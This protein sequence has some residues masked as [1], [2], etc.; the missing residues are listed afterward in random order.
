MIIYYSSLSKGRSLC[1]YSST[2]KSDIRRQICIL[3]WM[4]CVRLNKGFLWCGCSTI[5]NQNRALLLWRPPTICFRGF[6]LSFNP[7][8]SKWEHLA[9][10]IVASLKK[11]GIHTF[12][13]DIRNCCGA[14]DHLLL[15]F[16]FDFQSSLIWEGK[17]PQFKKSVTII[18]I[19]V[20]LRIS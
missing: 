6:A 4:E 11:R 2:Y 19:T 14:T 9:G 17:Y 15:W 8:S 13:M 18:Y 12:T 5:Y 7:P 10:R 1:F 16:C 3:K 20:F